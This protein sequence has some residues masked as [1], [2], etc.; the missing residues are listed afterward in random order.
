MQLY[1][2]HNINNN[3]RLHTFGTVLLL[4]F[5][6]QASLI[7]R[8]LLQEIFF[9]DVRLLN[10]GCFQIDFLLV[11]PKKQKCRNVV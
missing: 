4:F 5:L 7:Y 10:V 3:S 11:A 9:L 1:T 6:S 2:G 8:T